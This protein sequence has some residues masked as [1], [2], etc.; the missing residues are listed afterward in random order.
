MRKLGKILALGVVVSA[1][2]AGCAPMMMNGVSLQTRGANC[3]GVMRSA[4]KTAPLFAL[5]KQP[6]QYQARFSMGYN[7]VAA[8]HAAAK[9]L[10][11]GEC[12]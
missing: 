9:R 11:T 7:P 8:R 2:T 10:A 6:G 3:S 1:A 5:S 4:S 12:Y